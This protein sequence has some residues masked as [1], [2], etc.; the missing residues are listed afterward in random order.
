MKAIHSGTKACTSQRQCYS[1]LM[2]LLSSLAHDI[3]W[4]SCSTYSHHRH[5]SLQS[6]WDWPCRYLVVWLVCGLYRPAFCNIV[7]VIWDVLHFLLC[8]RDNWMMVLL[9]F[10]DLDRTR[11]SRLAE[12]LLAL[13]LERYN[14]SSAC[15]CK[16]VGYVYNCRVTSCMIHYAQFTPPTPTRQD[17]LVLSVFAVWTELETSQDCLRLKI[18]KQFC[19]V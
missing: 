17:C 19:P 14:I 9:I 12:D 7:A 1:A 11:F 13:M 16:T 15:S 6:G 18:S 4:P 2:A 10:N 8:H 5:E 3:R